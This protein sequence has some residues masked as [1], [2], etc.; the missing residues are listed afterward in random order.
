MV[1]SYA[2][3]VA[4]LFLS[5][6]SRLLVKMKSQIDPHCKALGVSFTPF[7]GRRFSQASAKPLWLGLTL[8]ICQLAT[9]YKIRKHRG[10]H[11]KSIHHPFVIFP[12]YTRV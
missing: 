7:N 10:D 12:A 2:M 9:Y 1:P 4:T 3:C 6:D 5:Q 11:K 8:L